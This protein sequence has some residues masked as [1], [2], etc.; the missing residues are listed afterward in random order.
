M[1]ARRLILALLAASAAASTATSAQAAPLARCTTTAGDR[2]LCGRVT[3]PLDRTGVVPG[4]VSLR[5]KALPP[6]GGSGAAGGAV[7]ALAGGPGQAAV[8]LLDA[9]ASALRPILRTRELVT[10]DQRGTGGSGRL[11]CAALSG[12]GTLSSVI[13]RCA[14]EL[15]PRRT[16]YTTAAS[17][18]DVEAVRAALGVD[19]LTLYAASYGT[20]VA[21]SYA[22]AYPQHVERL[23]LDSVVLPEGIDPFERSTLASIPRVLRATCQRACHFTRSPGADL[24]ALARRL[25]RR[26]LHGP[27]LDGRGHPHRARVSEVDLLSL[28]LDGDFDRYLRA[29]LPAAVRGALRGDAAPLLRLAVRSD[30]A[31]TLNAGSDSD[32][33]YVA[34]TCQDGQ[35][36]WAPGTP[37]GARRAAVD[38]AAAAIPSRAFLPFDRATVRTLGT[39]DLCRGWPESPIPQPLPPLPPTPT[40][41]MSGDEDLRTPRAD[42]VALAGRL[43]GAQLLEVPDAGH[44]ALFSD[45][46]DCTAN[47]LVAFAGGAA[48]RACSPHPNL[49]AASP[50]APRRL[51]AVPSAP[52]LAGRPGRTVT[53][54]LE[55]LD[56][57]TQQLIELL[58]GGGRA[59]SV[60]GLRAGSAAIG[61]DGSLRLRG[62]AYV[63]GVLVSGRLPTRASRFT[64]LVGGRAAAHGRLIISRRGVTGV[65]GGQ[66]IDLPARVLRGRSIGAAIAA[67]AARG[68][69]PTATPIAFRPFSY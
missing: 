23:V 11:R 30:A 7:L 17:V 8:P 40:L 38:A 18:Q 21:L 43:P 66:R 51:A 34:T 60:G 55:T 64:L 29:S 54:V 4:T 9:F 5:V 15:G 68:P 27:V 69:R 59:M 58:S 37:L 46:T 35:V 26:A 49:V 67:A 1:R 65:L 24:A 42:A 3:V 36:P 19:R 61:R 2:T 45:P 50:L 32:A 28:L 62:Y 22:A 33:V 31:D 25:G 53:A 48:V 47:A 14:S 44:G 41:V 39:A 12:R 10:F 52:R 6:A 16:T 56:D 20:K 63:P 57:A 13:E